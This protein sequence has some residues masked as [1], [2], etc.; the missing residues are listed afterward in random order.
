MKPQG[1]NYITKTTKTL[2]KH[3]IKSECSLKG[4]VS[5][6]IARACNTEKPIVTLTINNGSFLV[7]TAEYTNSVKL[8]IRVFDHRCPGW[9]WIKPLFC[10]C[11]LQK[12]LK[13][14]LWFSLLAKIH[15][16]CPSWCSRSILCVSEGAKAFKYNFSKF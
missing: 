8:S 11:I 15:L 2:G 12:S 6:V 3:S 4:T 9:K 10:A 13:N 14:L 7:Q 16:I 5:R 1:D